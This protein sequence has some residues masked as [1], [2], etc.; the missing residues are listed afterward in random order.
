M[1]SL[2]A[3]P[4][5]AVSIFILLVS[6]FLLC[7][8]RSIPEGKVWNGWIQLYV[9]STDLTESDVHAILVKNGC[10]K[11]IT[12]SNQKVPLVS[13]LSPIQ[14][15]AQDS[16]L[17]ARNKFFHDKSGQAMVFY[18][19]DSQSAQLEK[20]LL[21]LSSFSGTDSGTDGAVSFPWL[22]PIITF[23]LAVILLVNSSKKKIFSLGS[24]FPLMLSLSRPLFTVSSAS[25]LLIFAVYL[26][27]KFWRRNGF[28]HV[29]SN[30]IY[31]LI[32]A[33]SPFLLLIFSS[34]VN[35]FFYL[36]TASSTAS[37]L[38]LYLSYEMWCDSKISFQPVFIK[39]AKMIPVVGK[40]GLRMM[41]LLSLASVLF[42][43]SFKLS[44]NISSFSSGTNKPALPS[45]VKSS[46]ELPNFQDFL[47]WSWETLS[48]P[49]RKLNSTSEKAQEGDFVTVTDYEET[50]GTIHAVEKQVLTFDADFKNSVTKNLDALDYPALEKMLLKQGK[51]ANFAYTNGKVQASE[52]FGSVL[53]L[54]FTLIPILLCLYYIWGRKRYGLSI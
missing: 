25:C 40:K 4:K 38:Y 41:A 9:Y 19:P 37:L 1:T 2:L 46:L 45:P 30:S 14:L 21:E 24:V 32:P 8:F 3:K 54:I 34:P 16:F 47:N 31:F 23:A 39:S 42:L 11:T 51:N 13:K 5:T 50:D 18:I 36:V 48:F 43:G 33:F 17:I 22:S 44:G 12:I 26:F 49:Y 53:L 20:S 6:V 35:A 15:Q 7:R 27:Q 52:R 28:I 29:V 10:D